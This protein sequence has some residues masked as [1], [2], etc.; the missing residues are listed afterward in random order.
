MLSH[1]RT[2]VGQL[3]QNTPTITNSSAVAADQ[4]VGKKNRTNRKKTEGGEVG[5][6][7]ELNAANGFNWAKMMRYGVTLIQLTDCYDLTAALFGLLAPRSSLF[8][9]WLL[10]A[11]NRHWGLALRSSAT[12]QP[13]KFTSLATTPPTSSSYSLLPPLS[14]FLYLCTCSFEFL[15]ILRFFF[16]FGYF[17][18]GLLMAC[19]N[20][21][22]FFFNLI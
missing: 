3:S 6:G 13:L 16:F 17:N 22:L 4:F 10:T 9:Q 2:F 8:A 15:S 11:T 12:G 18:V 20:L 19:F 21:F 14:A 5:G 7:H 1:F